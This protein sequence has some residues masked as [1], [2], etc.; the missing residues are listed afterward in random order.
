VNRRPARSTQ[1][2]KSADVGVLCSKQNNAIQSALKEML[3]Q[4]IKLPLKERLIPLGGRA[5]GEEQDAEVPEEDCSIEDH[6][7]DRGAKCSFW[8]SGMDTVEKHRGEK[9]SGDFHA[10]ESISAYQRLDQRIELLSESIHH[11]KLADHSIGDHEQD[12]GRKQ[13]YEPTSLADAR[14]HG[15]D[16]IISESARESPVLHQRRA[17]IFQSIG[18][19]QPGQLEAPFGTSWAHA[20]QLNQ[21]PRSQRR[22]PPWERAYNLASLAS[23]SSRVSLPLPIGK[24]SATVISEMIRRNT[25]SSQGAEEHREGDRAR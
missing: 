25:N 11:E 8:T 7:E 3:A 19:L 1:N 5:L 16:H 18:W 4:G 17:Y 12:H 2:G 20:R 21:P 6:K 14:V 23:F 24:S 10:Q 9:S 15:D 22:G 13:L